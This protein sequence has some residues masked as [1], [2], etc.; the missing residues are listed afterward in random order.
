MLPLTVSPSHTKSV[1]DHNGIY[2][3]LSTNIADNRT[4]A[5]WEYNGSLRAYAH[6]M[7]LLTI[8]FN[9]ANTNNDTQAPSCHHCTIDSAHCSQYW[10]FKVD[11]SQPIM[12]LIDSERKSFLSVRSLFSFLQLE[13]CF[14]NW[15]RV[16]KLPLMSESGIF[17]FT[18]NQ[19]PELSCMTLAFYSWVCSQSILPFL[20]NGVTTSFVTLKTSFSKYNTLSLLFPKR[21]ESPCANRPLLTSYNNKSWMW[22]F[23]SYNRGPLLTENKTEAHRTVLDFRLPVS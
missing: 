17:L 8:P 4:T 9:S 20:E 5:H 12:I 22:M 10:H 3:D 19:Y 6:F 11:F 23:K 16:E 7:P 14:R 13:K 2:S 18:N 15:D 1:N 21:Q